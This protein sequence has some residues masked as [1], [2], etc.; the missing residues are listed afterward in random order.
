VK[1]SQFVYQPSAVSL[2]W[3]TMSEA[4]RRSHG[5]WLSEAEKV[6]ARMEMK[7][8]ACEL[9]LPESIVGA[10]H[11]GGTEVS[12]PSKRFPDSRTVIG[13]WTGAYTYYIDDENSQLTGR[14]LYY[15]FPEALGDPHFIKPDWAAAKSRMLE[16]LTE[17]HNL[18]VKKM[19]TIDYKKEKF[20][21]LAERM[22]IIIETIDYVMAQKN[23]DRFLLC[24]S[25]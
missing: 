20:R 3:E 8:K 2:K 9:G 16:I 12:F 14:D 22:E 1:F 18:D 10:Y 4:E 23:P 24:W 21:C 5:P 15:V 6:E 17:F 19:E 7:A 13:E 11:F 25:A